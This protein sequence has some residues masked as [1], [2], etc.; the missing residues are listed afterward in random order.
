LLIF[1]RGDVVTLSGDVADSEQS[2]LA[3][4][5]A[6]RVPGVGEVRNQ[7]RIRTRN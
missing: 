3:I 2:A 1:V 4:A 7:L 5:T 6:Q